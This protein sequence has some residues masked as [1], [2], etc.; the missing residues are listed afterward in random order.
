MLPIS[1]V[2]PRPK[3]LLLLIPPLGWKVQVRVRTQLTD[4]L[5]RP[6]NAMRGIGCRGVLLAL[7]SVTLTGHALGN[8]RPSLRCGS[9]HSLACKVIARGRGC[10]IVLACHRQPLTSCDVLMPCTQGREKKK[11]WENQ[12]I[13]VFGLSVRGEGAVAPV[14]GASNLGNIPS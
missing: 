14:R 5:S 1:D 11:G 8:A 2:G 3:R 6:N 7:V 9:M 12:R 10:Y 13:L 4:A